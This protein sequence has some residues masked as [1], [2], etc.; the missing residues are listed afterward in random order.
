MLIVGTLA[1][2]LLCLRPAL[3][4]AKEYGVSSVNIDAT[5]RTDGSLD[6][7]EE[8]TF[9][10]DGSFNVVFWD[11]P[12]G[13]FHDNEVAADVL[14]AGLVSGDTESSFKLSKGGK[15]T[16]GDDMVYTKE[17]EGDDLIRVMLYHPVSDDSCTYYLQYRLYNVVVRWDDVG[18]L[19]W[20]FVP[21]GWGVDSHNVSCVI[22][23]PFPEGS[24]K[25][26]GDDIRAWTHAP[27][28]G[29][30]EL[31]GEDVVASVPVVRARDMAEI[32]VTCDADWLTDLEGRKE[33][34]LDSIL[35]EEEP[36]D[37]VAAQ[38]DATRSQSKATTR[39]R[40]NAT[41]SQS[42]A[43]PQT[44]ANEGRQQAVEVIAGALLAVWILAGIIRTRLAISK[45]EKAALVDGKYFKDLP[46][47]DHPC[48]LAYICSSTFGR[49]QLTA[50]ILWLE[51]K[52]IVR[53]ISSQERDP[54]SGPEGIELVRMLEDK[55][56][57]WGDARR[58]EY[59]IDVA[60]LK[61]FFCSLAYLVDTSAPAKYDQIKP[62]AVIRFDELGRV[63][64]ER[65]R[66]YENASA[67]WTKSVSSAVGSRGK[68]SHK[69]DPLWRRLTILLVESVLAC[70]LLP[71]I[72]V[73]SAR[74]LGCFNGVSIFI[75]L[76]LVVFMVCC[77]SMWKNNT[78]DRVVKTRVKGLVRWL[79]EVAQE[80]VLPECD[81]LLWMKLLAIGDAVG[82]GR[83]TLEKLGAMMPEVPEAMMPEV[84]EARMPGSHVDVPSVASW[85]AVA[86]SLQQTNK[87]ANNEI[88]RI[89]A[90][91]ERTKR[92]SD[93]WSSYD[94]H[95][96]EER[97]SRSR[98]HSSSRSSRSHS[99]S[100]SGS[101]GS[102]SS[103]GGHGGGGAF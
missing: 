91:L 26:A 21:E 82:L 4:Y 93:S 53:V 63:A 64:K 72:T 15:A 52:G 103:H 51:A 17:R 16:P 87:V 8:R 60:T 80:G 40:T 56:P 68:P 34:A 48:T 88:R 33:S 74:A 94:D 11:I 102:S 100:R 1:V 81:P 83:K 75:E 32:R 7:R 61:Y 67:E 69:E 30:V 24:S 54:E 78:K 62:G 46:S 99:S 58:I 47:D 55:S 71:V 39:P 28:G 42:K 12:V 6:V 49:Q 2:L 18:E 57:E 98:H 92:E 90:E 65:P 10:F 70:V 44:S 31:T 23:L 84:P 86:A 45:E 41:R 76:V 36:S 59:A 101:S 97:Q 85:L 9:Y 13:V 22:H 96:S 43:K 37:D 79:E 50:S 73:V 5:M 19:Y 35:A 77:V 66:G 89:E 27:S 29:K 14:G 95:E 3:A 25:E 20:A 38:N